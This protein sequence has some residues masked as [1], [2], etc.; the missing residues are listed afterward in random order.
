MT[1][2]NL[3]IIFNLL[4]LLA[5]AMSIVAGATLW[6]N[7]DFV[8]AVIYLF[9]IASGAFIIIVELFYLP[10]LIVYLQCHQTMWGRVLFFTFLGCLAF[11]NGDT[12]H[13][14]CMVLILLVA[15][16]FFL[17]ALVSSNDSRDYVYNRWR[18][19]V[20]FFFL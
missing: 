11:Q 5:G 19:R 7:V 10:G 1:V 3:G 15:F 9:L 18:Q 14:I 12:L 6:G 20:L 8:R 17:W 2:C 13:I 16:I 4:S